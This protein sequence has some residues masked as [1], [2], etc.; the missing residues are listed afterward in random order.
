MPLTLS[1]LA[2]YHWG[3]AGWDDYCEPVARS[4]LDQA[5][6]TTMGPV[7]NLTVHWLTHLYSCSRPEILRSL[8][9]SSLPGA[10]HAPRGPRARHPSLG[11]RRDRVSTTWGSGRGRE[12]S[13]VVVMAARPGFH[14]VRV[15]DTEFK[16]LSRYQDL[17]KIGSGAQGV[18][19]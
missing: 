2:N 11:A 6:N 1:C 7:A 8:R 15:G 18:V 9:P 17:R 16:V 14:T 3:R 19:W 4:C 12:S 13:V 5:R 10:W